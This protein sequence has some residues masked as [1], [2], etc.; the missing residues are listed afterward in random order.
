V[1][2]VR[3]LREHQRLLVSRPDP[4]IDLPHV[5]LFDADVLIGMPLADLCMEFAQS[6]VIQIRWSNLLLEEVQRGLVKLGQTEENARRRVQR[7]REQ[8]PE[9]ELDL[10]PGHPALGLGDPNDEHVAFAGIEH[11][12]DAIIYLDKGFFRN[13][14]MLNDAGLRVLHADDWLCDLLRA[15]P[16][17]VKRTVDA[18]VARLR[19]PPVDLEI[20]L[21]RLSTRAPR[22]VQGLGAPR[23]D[24]SVA[25]F[26][27]SE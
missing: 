18:I 24:P 15:N 23:A 19:R 1:L 20:W 21:E 6:R 4:R 26:S 22:F 5:V 17:Q 9:A 2:E 16:I 7:M 11:G 14:Q 27:N 3:E 25:N 12:V 10:S 13:R 8:F